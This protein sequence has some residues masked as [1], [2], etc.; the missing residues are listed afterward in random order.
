MGNEQS[1][2]NKVNFED[3]KKVEKN[4]YI[5]INT[6]HANNQ[7]CLITNTIPID[8]EVYI[9]EKAIKEK[10]IIII[11]GK[12]TN[13]YTI[14]KKYNQLVSM[15]HKNTYLYCGGLFEWLLLQDIY[16]NEQF[17]TTSR[18]LDILKYKP[19]SDLNKL[20]IKN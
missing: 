3:I 6:L 16:G 7:Q 14:Y 12:N 19:D 13:D 1:S 8:K 15:G 9:V 2:I 4:D 20:L 11:Y 17:K 10:K 5:L 18:E